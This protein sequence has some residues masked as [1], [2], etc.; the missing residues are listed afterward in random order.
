M[1]RRRLSTMRHVAVLILLIIGTASAAAAQQPKPP[2]TG[3]TLTD[4]AKQILVPDLYEDE[5]AFDVESRPEIFIQTRFSRGRVHDAS[6][7]D[8]TQN[9]ELTRIESRWAGHLSDRVGVGL[10][11]QLHP[12]LEGAAEELVNDAFVEFYLT[13]GLTLRAG[14]FVKPFGFDVPRSSADREFPERG[15]FAGYFFPGQRDRGLMAIWNAGGDAP[16]LANTHVYAAILNGNRF[17]ADRDDTLDALFRV[18]RVFP[19]AG[20]AVGASLQIGSQLVP[21]DQPSDDGVT[22]VGLDAQYVLGP[23]GARLEVVRGTMPS[24]VLALE[25]E[26]TPA[27]AAGRTT[28][29][30]TVA[31]LV[32]LSDAQQAYTRFD[33]LS[34]DPVT[35]ER[36]SA[37]DVG[38]VGVLDEHARIG[39]N[40]QWKDT[41]TFND[42]AIN[43]RVQVTLGVV[44]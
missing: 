41:P 7:E 24:T 37:V 21:P 31:G 26:F 33:M 19:A 35:G 16:M 1:L 23:V 29:G 20:F 30:V 15:M 13:P 11:L 5:R 32:L 17:F 36:A 38:Y 27:Y 25:P 2:D 40:V 34:G 6:L 39:V 42:D 44:F 3:Q 12:A 8:A 28:S 14:Q 43:T 9:F 22:I 10:E 18:R 4:F